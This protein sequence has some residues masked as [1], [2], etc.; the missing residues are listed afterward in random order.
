MDHR[1]LIT[2]TM[3][4]AAV[5]VSPAQAGG[6]ADHASEAANH[7]T[8][9]AGHSAAMSGTV[10]AGSVALPLAVS[11]TTG[12]ASSQAAEELWNFAN[13]PI[14]SPLPITQETFTVGRSPREAVFNPGDNK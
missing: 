7:S 6:S 8:K 3:L 11:G 5:A 4:A 10:V 12:Q 14:G 2:V 9:S 1:T 13:Q